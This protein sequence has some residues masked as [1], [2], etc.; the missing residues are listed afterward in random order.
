MRNRFTRLALAALLATTALAAQATVLPYKDFKQLITEADGIV[1][2][3]VSAVQTVGSGTGD[4]DTYVTVDA[5]EVL[6]GVLAQRSLTLKLE[7]GF[8]GQRGLQIEGSPQFAAGERVL[9]FVQGNGVDVVPFVGWSQ[10]VFRISRDAA[11]EVDRV[12]G[13]DGQRVLGVRGQHLLREEVPH[14][15]VQIQ[16]QPGLAV[17]RSAP[18]QADAGQTDD[19]SAV[20]DVQVQTARLP[21]LTLERFLAL[22]REHA[23]AGRALQS[24]TAADAVSR[25]SWVAERSTQRTAPATHEVARPANGGVAEPARRP[26]P[27]RTT[28]EER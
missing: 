15:N 17:M 5:Q 27:A 10:G 8:D 4:I 28:R 1:L 14:G 12:T 19:G 2:G 20:A 18:A 13:A 26:V 23:G 11:E 21:A 22:V 16:G 9:V 24:V 25:P 6:S 7:G 3:T